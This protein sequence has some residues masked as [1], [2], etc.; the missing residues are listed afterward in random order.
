M[1]YLIA[2]ADR[3]TESCM[4]QNPWLDGTKQA[5]VVTL[6][7]TF[8]VEKYAPRFR[9]TL[10]FELAFR[11]G[12]RHCSV[13]ETQAKGLYAEHVIIAIDS[14]RMLKLAVCDAKME[15]LIPEFL[16]SIQPKINEFALEFDLARG[17]R[18]ARSPEHMARQVRA[19]IADLASESLFGN[20][21]PPPAP[22]FVPAGSLFGNGA[23]APA[24]SPA[25]PRRA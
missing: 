8:A 10:D 4:N 19:R 1:Q 24:P 15:S 21:A 17:Q 7:L 11:D 20:G 6:A 18:R 16:R 5:S 9:T 3:F 23:P 12:A 2:K 14:E 25:P 13:E 22:A